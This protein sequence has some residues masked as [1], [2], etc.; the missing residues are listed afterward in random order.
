MKTTRRY[1][2]QNLTFAGDFRRVHDTFLFVSISRSTKS[3]NSLTEDAIETGWIKFA[4]F[5]EVVDQRI[6]FAGV[7]NG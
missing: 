7:S 3:S 2:Q 5:G 6:S 1:N 4:V